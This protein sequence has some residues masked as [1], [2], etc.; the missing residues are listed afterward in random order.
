MDNKVEDRIRDLHMRLGITAAQEDAWKKVAEVMRDN[1]HT[2]AGLI[3]TRSEKGQTMTA[4]DD[5]KSYAEIAKAHADGVD[6]FTP[7]F[8]A[9]Y[10]S[11]PD[12]QK[13]KADSIFRARS[14]HGMKHMGARHEGG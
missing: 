10:D 6:R 5:L 2:M 14:H 9:L 3:Q 7:V 11:M 12:D 1:A 4:V 13:K 8:A